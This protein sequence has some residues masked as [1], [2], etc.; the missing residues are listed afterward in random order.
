MAVDCI[1]QVAVE[2]YDKLKSVMAGFDQTHASTNGDTVLLKA[3]DEQLRL[4]AQVAGCLGLKDL[5]NV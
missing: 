3:V 2:F 4:S 5:G 1:P